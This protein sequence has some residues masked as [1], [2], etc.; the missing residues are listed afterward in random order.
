VE[1]G[2]PSWGEESCVLTVVINNYIKPNLTKYITKGQQ[3]GYLPRNPPPPVPECSGRLL[4]K[5]RLVFGKSQ[6]KKCE[7]VPLYAGYQKD[8]MKNLLCRAKNNERSLSIQ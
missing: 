5:I 3:R 2:R 6:R 8:F 7:E 1:H 4:Y